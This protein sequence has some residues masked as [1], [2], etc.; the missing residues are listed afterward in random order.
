MNYLRNFRYPEEHGLCIGIPDVFTR[1]GT[2]RYSQELQNMIL[3]YDHEQ[4]RL[5]IIPT[6]VDLVN[7][8]SA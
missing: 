4:K 8:L 6:N 5:G 2:I 1:G 3:E 7:E